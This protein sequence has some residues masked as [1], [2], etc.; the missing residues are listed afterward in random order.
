[1]PT[2]QLHGQ[3]PSRLHQQIVAALPRIQNCADPQARL[4]QSPHGA[5]ATESDQ[6]REEEQISAHDCSW[7]EEQSGLQIQSHKQTS[8]HTRGKSGT[9][10]ADFWSLSK[11]SACYS[12]CQSW[13]R[14][15]DFFQR[16]CSESLI[17]H[18]T[19]SVRVEEDLQTFFNGS[20]QN[21]SLQKK[22]TEKLQNWLLRFQNHQT[23]RR[24]KGSADS[25]CACISMS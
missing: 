22:T 5:E 2:G 23:S 6:L 17:L 9:K 11:I 10:K 25:W 3:S 15:T 4:A 20:A 13:R 7:Q 18:A 21:L 14:F 19:A 24:F 16:F 12:F 1:M 8:Q